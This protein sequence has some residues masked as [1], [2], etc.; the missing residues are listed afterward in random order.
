[1]SEIGGNALI[2]TIEEAKAKPESCGKGMFFT[3][4][5]ISRPDGSECAPNE[6][7]AVLLRGPGIMAGYWRNP[8][9]TVET[10]Q[11][12]WLH[13]GDIGIRDEDGD[14]FF[15]D[16]AKELVKCGGFNVS[17]QEIEDLLLEIEGIDEVA[18]FAV[19]D[20]RYTEVPF[21]LVFPKVPLDKASVFA[22]CRER[23]AN[24]KLPR[25]IEFV[26]SP[27]PRLVRGKVDKQALKKS[28]ADAMTR[29]EKVG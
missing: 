25:Y 10:I 4:F 17:P 7:G 12:G 11:D 13:T 1:M 29:F 21:A 19:A 14:F 18:V 15:V 6:P 5:R 9:A 26:E 20:E 24:Y 28:Y 22:F 27:L 23:L 2:A 16:R 3:K 8:E